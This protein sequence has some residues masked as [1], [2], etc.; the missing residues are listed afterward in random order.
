[1]PDAARDKSASAACISIS[2]LDSPPKVGRD[3]THSFRAKTMSAPTTA[4]V[5]AYL[6]TH[7]IKDKLEAALTKAIYSRAADPVAAIA[8]ALIAAPPALPPSES[9]GKKFFLGANWKC[10]IETKEAA[11]ALVADLAKKEWPESAE[12]V[13]FA[14]YLL[15]PTLLALAPSSRFAIGAQSVWDAGPIGAFTGCT[16]ATALA[17]A[18]V[19]WVLLGHSDRRNSLGESSELIA[20][21]AKLALKAGLLVNLTVGETPEQ[22]A[23]NEEL[24]VLG[25]QLAPVVAALAE[26]PDAWAKIVLAYEPVWAIGD[27][28]T[29]CSPEEAQRIHAFL[30]GYVKDN[31]SDE[32]ATQVR[33]AY[34]GSVSPGNAASYKA[35]PDVDGFVCGR[36]S[37]DATDFLAVAE[38]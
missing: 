5:K 7:D 38:A 19:K 2:L 33:V 18:G 25:A 28:A 14:P 8:A 12:I 29:P 11:T 4:E 27:G 15:L 31:V 1:M 21:K 32:A 22:R 17:A 35:L 9:G 16:T 13:L 34:T 36:A 6:A 26:T 30:R 20:E 24:T 37:L 23:A 3:R 10:K